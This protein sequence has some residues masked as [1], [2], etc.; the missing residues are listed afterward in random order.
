MTTLHP[1]TQTPLIWINRSDDQMRSLERRCWLGLLI[2]VNLGLLNNL[3]ATSLIYDPA[4]VASGEWW[5]LL[6]WPLIH[7]SRYHLLLDGAAFLLLLHGLEE[8]H[9]GKRFS[10][11]FFSAA[12]SLLL[13]LAV[14]P[15]LAQTGLCG[16]SGIA[17]GLA[18]VSALEMI[19]SSAETP[20]HRRIGILLLAGLLAKSGFELWTGQVLF[21]SLHLGSVGIPVVETHAGGV[22]GGIFA[23]LL[24][25]L[26]GRWV[27]AKKPGST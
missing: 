22:L 10:L 23:Q 18:T 13:P 5:R 2:L 6:T 15:T 11:V 16:L 20:A 21:A 8:S 1:V 27:L 4:A 26:G 9:P 3:P 14:T 7:V 24:H 12:G 19:G 17:H 25:Q